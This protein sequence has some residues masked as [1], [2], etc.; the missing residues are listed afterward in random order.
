MQW[1]TWNG[2]YE[3]CVG[4]TCVPR[5][6]AH[7]V[8]SQSLGIGHDGQVHDERLH[9]VTPVPFQVWAHTKFL[10]LHASLNTRA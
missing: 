10:P 5:I 3:I 7:A 6:C 4:R 9:M 1:L 8:G 2:G